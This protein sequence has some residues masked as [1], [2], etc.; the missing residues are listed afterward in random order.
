MR[1]AEIRKRVKNWTGIVCCVGVAPTKTLAK[2]CNHIAKK[3]FGNSSTFIWDDISS[4]IQ[5]RLLAHT[6]VQELWG[7]GSRTAK[8]L[9]ALK[10]QT[11]LDLKNANAALL[12]K[13]FG[14]ILERTQKELQGLDCIEFDPTMHPPK[15]GNW[16]F[17]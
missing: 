6:P 2:L 4:E 17:P 1:A 8:A 5:N 14:V 11:A 3:G 13:Q 7:V 10:I 9:S 15:N 12:R 16:Q